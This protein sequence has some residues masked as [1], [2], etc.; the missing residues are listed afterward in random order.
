V[1]ELVML[2]AVLVALA[3]AI[4]SYL[5]LSSMGVWLVRREESRTERRA[6]PFAEQ[7]APVLRH[8]AV[9]KGIRS[10]WSTADVEVRLLHAGLSWEVEEYTALRWSVLWLSFGAA[11]GLVV[12]R[13]WDLVGQFLA[14]LVIISGVVGPEMW[15]TRLVERR[16]MEVD[17]ALPNLLDRLALGLE[18]GLSFDLAIQ[19]IAQ[20]LPDL[21]GSDMR[22]FVRQ[23]ERGHHREE[24]LD[25]LAGRNPS[26]DLRAFVAAVK[27]SDRLGTSLAEVLRMQTDLLRARR[28]RRAEEASRRLPILIIF[29]LVFFF[30][31][32]LMIVYLAPPVLHLFTVR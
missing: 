28:R 18:A 24:A 6:I 5:L 2:V 11:L 13:G 26:T 29:P 8:I 10:R 30:L 4:L 15:L 21:L 27:Q 32:A 22:L 19:R 20:N 9:P 17:L 23:I 12:W 3:V 1:E 31:P 14:L 16:Q 7:L 25:E